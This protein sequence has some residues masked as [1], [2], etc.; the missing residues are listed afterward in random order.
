MSVS[1]LLPLLGLAPALWAQG[2]QAVP[3]GRTAEL[4]G[5]AHPS[6]EVVWVTGSEGTV[7]LSAD[8]GTT[9]GARSVPGGAALDFRDVEAFDAS[10]AWLLAAG[11]GDLGRIYRTSDGGATWQLQFRNP[12]G[13]GFLNALAF[14]DGRR[15]LALGDPIR[16]RFQILRTEDG[17]V[18]WEPIPEAGMP[19]ALEGEGAFASSGTCLRV[20]PGAEA[21]FVT[22]SAARTRVFHS[23]DG[24]RTWSVA[25]TPVPAGQASRGL[26][27]LTLLGDGRALAL[28]GDHQL[29]ALTTLNGALTVDGGRT[30][31]A[32]AAQPTGYLSGS[33]SVPGLSATLVAVGLAGSGYSRDGGRTWTVL[34]TTPLNAVAFSAPSSG[35][36]VGPRGQVFRLA[37]SLETGRPGAP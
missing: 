12:A 10:T 24:G 37:G 8:G 17:G 14:W 5:L 29:P 1:R 26:F 31:R 11:P 27:T 22:G 3:V 19:A 6:R 36:A 16:G 30:W 18:H 35:W 33:S 21:W 9:W 23:L 2:W 28:G 4:R 13:E 7:L 25:D 20:G 32:A 34:G 15:G